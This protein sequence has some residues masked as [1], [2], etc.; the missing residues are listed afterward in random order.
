LIGDDSRTDLCEVKIKKSAAAAQLYLSGHKASLLPMSKRIDSAGDYSVTKLQL[1]KL[2]QSVIIL[3]CLNHVYTCG[4]IMKTD[5]KDEELLK[6]F[7]AE[8]IRFVNKEGDYS[9]WD[10]VDTT[11][12]VTEI[13]QSTKDT[14]F[15]SKNIQ[16][17]GMALRRSMTNWIEKYGAILK[18]TKRAVASGT[19]DDGNAPRTQTRV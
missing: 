16:K 5:T 8:A 1:L 12:T 2:F 17:K 4:K 11:F 10:E 15:S 13:L 14:A 7:Q 18:F 6:I 19:L 3:K 9:S